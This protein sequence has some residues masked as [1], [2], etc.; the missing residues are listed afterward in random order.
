VTTATEGGYTHA[1]DTELSVVTEDGIALHVEVDEGSVAANA[2]RRRSDPPRPTVVLSHGYTLSLR[3]WVLQRRAL[4]NAGYRVVLWDQRSHG[5][6]DVAPAESC[7][8]DRIG[9]DLAAVIARTCPD[10]PVVLVGH[11]MG[12]MTMMSLAGQ[13]PDLIRSRVL[14]AAFVATSAGG[15]GMTTLGFGPLLGRAIGRVGPGVLTRLGRHQGWLDRFRRVGRDVEEV[16][17]GRYSFDSQVS[18][19]LVRFVGDM[20]FGTPL[21]V[22]A[23][24]M[25]HIDRL[26]ELEHLDAFQGIEVLV[27]NGEGDMLTPP[28]HSEDIV[29][30]IPGAEHVVVEHAGHLIMLEH[31]E[32]VTQQ[33]LMLIDRAERAHA[34]GIAMT[35]KPRVRRM[36]TE[37][38]PRRRSS[39]SRSAS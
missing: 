22:M 23:A 14:A 35:R 36:I 28:S 30:R 5:R 7:T 32:L 6:S 20:I 11:S 19:D 34:E 31:P 4:V 33:L 39:R 15:R 8:V 9:A 16:V 26:D 2:R 18:D 10:G 3:S 17:V 27:M 21:E 29:R 38:A 37:L 24:F 25:P 13:H 12:G 1:A